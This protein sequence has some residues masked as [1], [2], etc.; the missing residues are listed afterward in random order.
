MLFERRLI[1]KSRVCVNHRI[2]VKTSKQSMFFTKFFFEW[3][4]L[5]ISWVEQSNKHQSEYVHFVII[6][7]LSKINVVDNEKNEIIIC[8]SFELKEWFRFK[9]VLLYSLHMLKHRQCL[10]KSSS[11]SSA[12][13]IS[14]LSI[15]WIF[16]QS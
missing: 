12:S 5:L 15:I 8:F 11:S 6:V 10:M 13:T 3:C 14:K 7:I 2:R 4:L 9:R 16:F 1:E